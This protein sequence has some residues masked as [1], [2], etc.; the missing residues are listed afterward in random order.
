MSRNVNLDFRPEN[1]S[2]VDGTSF[3][4]LKVTC[5]ILVNDFSVEPIAYDLH[6]TSYL[7]SVICKLLYKSMVYLAYAIG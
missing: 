7:S 1:F 2:V 3:S 4:Y 5:S 6:S